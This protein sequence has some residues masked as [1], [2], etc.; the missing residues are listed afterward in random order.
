MPKLFAFEEKA[1]S[2][3]LLIDKLIQKSKQPD[4]PISLTADLLKQRQEVA[5]EVDEELLKQKEQEKEEPSEEE[6]E[7]GEEESGESDA[8]DEEPEEEPKEDTGKSD[9]S[10]ADDEGDLKSLIGT[11]LNGDKDDNPKTDKADKTE[12]APATESY[13]PSQKL[14]RLFTPILHQYQKYCLSL[15]DYNLQ[16]KAVAADK[17]A[18]AYV[19]EPVLAS[20]KNL[21]T[22]SFKYSENITSFITTIGESILK[23]N[24][25]VTV[26]NSLVEANNYHFTHK[27]VSDKNILANVSYKDHSD[28]RETSRA[29][30]KY[31]QD[32]NTAIS[33]MVNNSFADMKSAFLNANFVQQESELAYHKPI[34]GFNHV[35]V[36]LAPY[37]NYLKTKV[38]DFHYYKIK[39][40]KAEDV[41]GLTAISITEDRDLEY[42]VKTISDLL[43]SVTV[44]VDTLKGVNTNFENFTKDLKVLAYNVEND[45]YANMTELGIDERLQDFI[46]FKLALE[47]S[48]ININMV[49][50]YIT[51]ILSVIDVCV[52]LSE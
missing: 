50:D 4:S 15:E 3:E 20:I 19:K 6:E 41:Y 39:S 21:T 37:T 49:L 48:Y 16:D 9:E 7:D 32:S 46:K 25:R 12:K 22:V 1:S 17:Q 14:S 35:A 5:K 26:L 29:L 10:A 51:S 30:L 23:L 42:I 34:P 36:G 24:E 18:V 40:S 11:G 47:A 28:P 38:E 44:S 33:M 43:I 31:Q 27:L 45:Q 13:K 8:N 52:E 2:N